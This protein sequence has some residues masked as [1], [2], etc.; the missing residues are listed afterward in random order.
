MSKLDQLDMSKLDRLELL[1]RQSCLR[2]LRI[3]RIALLRTQGNSLRAIAQTEDISETQ[4]RYDLA[5]A[6]LRGIPWEPID[7]KV[8]GLDGRIQPATK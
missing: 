2:D 6:K 5:E 7:G 1:K 8:H 3:V 4:V